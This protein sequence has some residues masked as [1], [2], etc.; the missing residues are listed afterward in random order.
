MKALKLFVLFLIGGT[1]YYLLE[2]LWRGYSHLSMFVVGGIC[3]IL[4]GGINEYFTFEMPLLKQMFISSIIITIIEFIAGIILN[5][6]LKLN[7]WNYANLPFNIMGQVCLLYSVLW[8]G[9]S[10]IA[11]VLDDYLRHWLFDEPM[12]K[13]K[14]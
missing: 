10:L 12:E 13:Y 6:W 4:V 3:F 9:L 5:I 11:I 1:I 14:L 2:V 8:F 7:I